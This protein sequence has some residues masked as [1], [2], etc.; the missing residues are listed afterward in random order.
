M[1]FLIEYNFAFDF[2]ISNLRPKNH[3]FKYFFG[4]NIN[5]SAYRHWILEGNPRNEFVKEN[6][7]CFARTSWPRKSQ[8]PFCVVIYFTLC[9]TCHQHLLGKWHCME[10]P[11]APL[12]LYFFSTPSF[13]QYCC[14]L[15]R[16]DVTW[17]STTYV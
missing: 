12:S 5:K 10:S 1:F 6:P 17:R 3:E 9:F 13:P 8:L 16:M 11:Q 7:A 14:K 2:E 4:F 15:W